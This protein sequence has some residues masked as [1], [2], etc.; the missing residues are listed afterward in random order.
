MKSSFSQ[1]SDQIEIMD[2]LECKGEVVNQ[3]FNQSE[4]FKRNFNY[5]FRMW[6]WGYT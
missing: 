2:D 1:R 4:K 5:R 3:T 6:R